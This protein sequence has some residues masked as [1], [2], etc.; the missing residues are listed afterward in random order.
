MPQNRENA[1]IVLEFDEVEDDG[2][3]DAERQSVFLVQK[4]FNENA[5]RPGILHLGQFQQGGAG[6]EKDVDTNVVVKAIFFLC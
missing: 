5:V 4:S 1:A 3:D 2:V 6:G